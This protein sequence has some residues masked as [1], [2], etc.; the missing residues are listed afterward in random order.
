MYGE[1][2]ALLKF[3]KQTREGKF[4][5]VDE[6]ALAYVRMKE[7]REELYDEEFYYYSIC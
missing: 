5:E 7:E 3:L 4:A 2:R 6:S 1:E